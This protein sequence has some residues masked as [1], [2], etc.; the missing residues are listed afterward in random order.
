V[1]PDDFFNSIGQLLPF[2]RGDETA[3]RD[4]S[5]SRQ[6][7]PVGRLNG[8]RPTLAGREYVAEEVVWVKLAAAAEGA[9][10]AS[11]RLWGRAVR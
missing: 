8:N 9:R 5:I 7:R 3:F 11:H 10:I 1:L 4:R 6:E 2:E